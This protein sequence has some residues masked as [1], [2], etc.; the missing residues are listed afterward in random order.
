MNWSA[1]IQGAGVLANFIG[2][3]KS[4]DAA[5][6]AADDNA[7]ITLQRAEN[8]SK[9]SLHDASVIELQALE[10]KV[11]LRD[12]IRKHYSIIDKILSTARTRYGSAGVSTKTGSARDVLTD[13]EVQGE[14]DATRILYEG[15][16]S[17][18]RM[19][20]LAKRYR[21]AASYG[22]SDSAA[23]ASAISEAGANTAMATNIQ[24][25]SKL[26]TNIY[27]IGS[28]QGWFNED[29]E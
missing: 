13:I 6:D 16:K 12:D 11:K 3:K 25:W 4:A 14:Q 21:N 20:N 2:G 22:L 17:Y 7:A 27:Q 24:N 8:N 29:K 1:V 23:H 28:N 10:T 26:S 9:L 19:R 15:E 18:D 5:Q